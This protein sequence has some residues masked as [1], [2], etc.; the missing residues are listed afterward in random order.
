MT[1]FTAS[2]GYISTQ[3]QDFKPDYAKDSGMIFVFGTILQ[4]IR[5]ETDK[6]QRYEQFEFT[7]HYK[8]SVGGKAALQ[9]LA[10]AKAGGKTAIVSKTGD[11][12][13]AKHILFRL[14]K[15]GVITSAVGKAE[16][17][18]TG[19]SI[20]LEHENRTILG[21][22]ASAKTA[23][24]QVPEETL[25][26]RNVVLMQTEIGPEENSKLLA[27][28]YEKGAQTVFNASPRF[29][30]AE[31]DLP[32][33]SYLI[34]GLHQKDK[35]QTMVGEKA[36]NVITIFISPAGDVELNMKG[37]TT[38]IPKINIEGLDWAHP[39]GYEDA[40]CGTFAAGL[41]EGLPLDKTL[42]RAHIAA[43]LTA[44]RPGGYD[45]IPYSDE[46]EECLKKLAEQA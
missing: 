42:L 30:I 32:H 7:K 11:D 5:I 29:E 38:P 23:A 27:I 10:A 31:E 18:Q 34:A 25:S 33:I 19:T 39:E 21:L 9:A 15:H 14:R 43:A 13:L 17:M 2:V 45:T 40:F 20:R 8:N 35:W 16:K 37:K 36:G 6:E 24:E 46:V 1:R 41:Y 22:G 26:E 44:S 3:P 28:A 12:E 4:L